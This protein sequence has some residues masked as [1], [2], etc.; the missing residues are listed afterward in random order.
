MLKPSAADPKDTNL[1][2]VVLVEKSIQSGLAESMLHDCYTVITM[3]T[4]CGVSLATYCTEARY[5]LHRT[6]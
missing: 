3:Y 2:L 5:I 4:N 6:A 1:S